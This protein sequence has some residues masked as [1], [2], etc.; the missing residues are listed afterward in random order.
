[1]K[2][3]DLT[4]ALETCIQAKRPAFVT[5]NPG[6]GKSQIM[7]QTAARLGYDFYDVRLS[8]RDP[9]DVMG[10]PRI[11]GDVTKWCAPALLP[12]KGPRP[13]VLFLDE[14]NRA[15]QMVLNVGL[16]LVLDGRVGDYVLP[17]DCVVM[18]AGNPESDPGVTRMSSAMKL[19][20]IHL[21]LE[22]SNDDWCQ[23]AVGAGL[24]PVVIGF[25]RFRPELLHAFD[26]KARVSP[27]PRAWQFV[28]DI[29]RQNPNARIA[30]ELFVGVLGE[31]A[32]IEFSGFRR[33]YSELPQIDAILLEPHKTKVPADSCTLYAV[34]AALA[35][36][37]SAN[38]F[39]RI[40]T[41]LER[42]PVEY[43]V[44]AVKMAAGRQNGQLTS[45]PEFTKWAVAHSDV[46]F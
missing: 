6:M 8:G 15:S 18:A 10:L 22:V 13:S 28:S 9:V 16:Q 4:L 38:N 7:A 3:S 11:E 23:W 17:A 30:H 35:R 14:M 39:G 44:L 19:R 5:S 32:A 37:A 42:M 33:L 26:A 21:D 24:E 31:A 36:R 20:F 43:N 41:Y 45:T 27:N 12:K 34:A 29:V 2:P 40:L 46:T 1:M 25:L